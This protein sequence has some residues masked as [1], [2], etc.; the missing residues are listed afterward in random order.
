[1]IEYKNQTIDWYGIDN[2]EVYDHNLKNRYEELLSNGWVDNY[3]DVTYSLNEHGFRSEPFTEGDK[4]V[5]FLGSSCTFGTGLPLENTWPYIVSKEIGLKRYNLA[6][7]GGSGCT[8]FRIANFWLEKL[9][10]VLVIYMSPFNGRLEIIQ[11]DTENKEYTY[12][13]LHSQLYTDDV[14]KLFLWMTDKF[15]NNKINS[16]QKYKEFYKIWSQTDANALLLQYKNNLSIQCIA[17]RMN[18][19]FLL[20]DDAKDYMNFNLDLARDLLHTGKNSHK[21]LAEY[22]LGK[23][24]KVGAGDENRTRA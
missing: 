19:K 15:K 3:K 17:E 10:P 1:M 21:M 18:S 7:G 22:V 13:W 8:N 11:Q 12:D 5:V 20:L 23:L 16:T 9:K 6:L 24:D 4:S 2:K 14:S